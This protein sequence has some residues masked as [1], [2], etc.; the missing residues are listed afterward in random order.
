VTH[1]AAPEHAQIGDAGE[2]TLSAPANAGAIS[3]VRTT[4]FITRIEVSGAGIIYSGRTGLERIIRAETVL[5]CTT[6][7]ADCKCPPGSPNQEPPPERGP[8]Q[9]RAAVTGELHNSSVMNLRGISKDEWCGRTPAPTPTATPGDP[10]TDCETLLPAA[11]VAAAVGVDI[12]AP[13]SIAAVSVFPVACVWEATS[14][15]LQGNPRPDA[16]VRSDTYAG[17]PC[18]RSGATEDVAYCLNGGGPG[19]GGNI[20]TRRWGLILT[21][22]GLS[23]EQVEEGL[24]PILARTGR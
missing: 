23:V 2:S 1:R 18:S 6:T 19:A 11:E 4:A 24:V 3:E 16:P 15:S 9:F 12:G 21:A 22:H 20:T 5:Y 8:D 17:L 10:N 13:T 14:W 7:G